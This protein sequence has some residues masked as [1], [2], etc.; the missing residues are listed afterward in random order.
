MPRFFSISVLALVLLAL[1]TTI[2][3]GYD[4]VLGP[5][6]PYDGSVGT[7]AGQ[8][9]AARD[10]AAIS[11]TLGNTAALAARSS[12]GILVTLED[13]QFAREKNLGSLFAEPPW[14]VG[15]GNLS[16]GLSYTYLDYKRLNG[17]D[18]DDLYDITID[19]DPLLFQKGDLSLRSHVVLFS[20]N[21]GVF[22]NLDLGVIV[23][24]VWLE[25][26]GSIDPQVFACM[27]W[28]SRTVPTTPDWRARTV[29]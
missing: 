15:K 10:A 1:P 8:D 28:I 2:A 11:S 18:L 12:A 4:S 6:S 20:A 25:G 19:D 3:L 16:L 7:K 21:Y 22:E 27:Q 14:T 17:E 13:G 9:R 24:Y 5:L 23:P 26:K 29:V